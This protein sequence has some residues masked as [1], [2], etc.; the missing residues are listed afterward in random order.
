MGLKL[1]SRDINFLKIKYKRVLLIKG[2]LKYLILKG[3][4]FNRNL[5]VNY[6]MVSYLFINERRDFNKKYHNICRYSSYTKGVNSFLGYGRH[7]INRDA[8]L[9]NLQNININSW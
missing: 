7:E 6:R 2:N 1:K 5:N 3:I 8:I 4:F 9:G